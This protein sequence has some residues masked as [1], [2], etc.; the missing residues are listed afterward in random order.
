MKQ[1]L[2][3]LKR[4]KWLFII[5]FAVVFIVPVVFSLLFMRTYEANT[6]LWLDSDLSI[7]SVLQGTALENAETTTIEQESKTL[8]QLLESRTFVMSVIEKTPLQKKMNT[9]KGRE[10]AIRYV[11]RNLGL[12]VVGP[13]ALKITFFGDTR[14]ESVVFAKAISDSFIEWVR[15][16]VEEQNEKSSTF[17]DERANNYR[18]ELARA[19]AELAAYKEAHPETRQ[20]IVAEMVLDAP[21]ITVAPAVQ[22]EYRRLT[23]AEQTAE[24]LYGAALSDAAQN[25]ALIAAQ[26]ERYINGLRVVD[27]PVE[28]TSFA[29]KPLLLLAFLAFIAAIVVAA[30]AVILAEYTDRTLHSEKDVGEALDLT[31][32]TEVR[33]LA[34]ARRL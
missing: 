15:V 16:A 21:E 7:T 34:E 19:R 18:E 27:E 29:K 6:L 17:F 8:E 2:E 32:L 24:E 5:P 12:Y 1:V 14:E 11:Q 26:Y 23:L 22:A 9:P 20:L 31:V 4:R 25:R 3:I 13:N 28:P 33:D 10:K 30:G